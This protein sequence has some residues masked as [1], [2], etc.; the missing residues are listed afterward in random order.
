MISLYDQIGG[1]ALRAV[2]DDFCDRMFSD[3]I[4]CFLFAGKDKHSIQQKEWEMTAAMLGANVKYTGRSLKA[5]HAR[6][7]IL[8]G[9]FYRRAMILEQTLI[10]R[11]VPMAVRDAWIEHTFRLQPEIKH[12]IIRR[13]LPKRFGLFV[14]TTEQRELWKSRGVEDLLQKTWKLVLL[15]T[16]ERAPSTAVDIEWRLRIGVIKARQELVAFQFEAA[17][18]TMAGL[19]EFLVDPTQA[20]KRMSRRS[21]RALAIALT[22]FAPRMTEALWEHMN[23]PGLVYLQRYPVF[24]NFNNP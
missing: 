18:E 5:A 14:G 3:P 17:V 16:A 15:K 2:V 21:L 7:L 11:E 4:I 10:D 9:H 13:Q 20:Q 22:S 12:A 8:E 19:L 6:S 24:H 23:E 1:E